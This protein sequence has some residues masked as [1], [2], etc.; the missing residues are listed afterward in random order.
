[1]QP[2]LPYAPFL[3]FGL[4]ILWSAIN[5]AWATLNKRNESRLESQIDKLKLYIGDQLKG[6][7]RWA[8][9]EFA[10]INEQTHLARRIYTLEH[11]N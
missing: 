5:A 11:A 6:E 1:M 7:R 10:T 8:T 3:L 4:N 2:W 9:E